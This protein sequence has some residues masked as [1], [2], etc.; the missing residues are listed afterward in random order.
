M[1]TFL[2]GELAEG[3]PNRATVNIN[4]IGYEVH[5]PVSTYDKLPAVG[6]QVHLLTHL[7]VRE[8]EHT[9][10]GFVSDTERDL[11]RLLIN[12]VSG[13]GP[14]MALSI[15]SGMPVETFK[16][17]VA[18]SDIAAL[19]RIKGVGKKTAERIV[20][21]LRDKVGA[22]SAW[23]AAAS[24]NLGAAQ[25]GANDAVL[26][27]LTLGYKQVEAHK[28]VKEFLATVSGQPGPDEMLR[29]ALRVLNS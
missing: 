27:L 16:A 3:L 10:Y 26:A 29:G 21:E 8:D 6:Q 12:Q 4:G 24:A 28:A 5:I 9:L 23:Q 15:L 20:V 19:S 7:Q 25:G 22:A 1:I 17:C 11:F 2:K 13:I 14:K 18:N